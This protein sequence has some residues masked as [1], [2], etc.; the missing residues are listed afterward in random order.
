MGRTLTVRI[1]DDLDAWI[2]AT[3]RKRGISKGKLV[4]DQ[5]EMSRAS[6]RERPFMRLAGVV[7]GPRNLSARKGFS[8]E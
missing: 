3:A 8:K 5:L 1:D 2:E 7:S 6:V 4:R